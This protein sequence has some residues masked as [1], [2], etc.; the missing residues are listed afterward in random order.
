MLAI[1]VAASNDGSSVWLADAG[2]G[3][4]ILAVRFV[5]SLGPL[6]RATSI[7]EWRFPGCSGNVVPGQTARLAANISSAANWR[8]RICHTSAARCWLNTLPG[9]AT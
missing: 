3:Q 7:G 2:K 9:F 6:S 1:D 5:R 4:V 8:R